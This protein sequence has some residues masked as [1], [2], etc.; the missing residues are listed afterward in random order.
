MKIL[1]ILMVCALAACGGK[2]AD[3]STPT[4]NTDPTPT[5]DGVPCT[6]EIALQCP[7]GQIDGCLKT[8]A[9]GTTHACVAP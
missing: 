4:A 7:E 6:Q 1:S 3:P 5:G 9:E 8:P 2:K